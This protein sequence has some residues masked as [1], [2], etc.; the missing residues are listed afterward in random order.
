M[1][2]KNAPI[3]NFIF[4]LINIR[5]IYEDIKQNEES[6]KV[7]T[8]LGKKAIGYC[9]LFALFVAIA[10]GLGKWGYQ[11]I[12]TPAFFLGVIIIVIA[13]VFGLY[14]ISFLLFA[15]SCAMKQIRLN[16]RP[17]GVIALI[18]TLLLLVIVG[19]VITIVLKR[20]K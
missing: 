18:L 12:H 6:K 16:R 13:I 19:V 5:T 14:S 17:V 4:G 7:S 15:F 11:Y 2:S 3:L 20:I 10:V 8:V 1:S 9:F